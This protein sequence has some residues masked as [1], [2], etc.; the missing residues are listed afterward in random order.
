MAHTQR[1]ISQMIIFW[2][3]IA[4]SI[5]LITFDRNCWFDNYVNISLTRNV[6]SS[7]LF[8]NEP[9]YLKLLLHSRFSSYNT[10]NKN[11]LIMSVRA[12]FIH[13][14]S[15]IR[16]PIFPFINSISTDIFHYRAYSL[17]SLNYQLYI[18]AGTFVLI[19]LSSRYKIIAVHLSKSIEDRIRGVHYTVRHRRACVFTLRKISISPTC[20]ACLL[21]I[22]ITYMCKYPAPAL[23]K[24]S[25]IP[26]IGSGKI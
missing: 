22:D 1:Y 23:A 6:T 4:R 21:R 5:T 17:V 8:I 24:Y 9:K 14:I 11:P 13:Y 7:L 26:R 20:L 15:F 3:Q 16:K 2:A 19:Y 25:P 10:S 12:V 18:Y